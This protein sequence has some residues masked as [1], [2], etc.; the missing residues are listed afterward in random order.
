MKKNIF[1]SST[2]YSMP[3][4][5]ITVDYGDG[6]GEQSWSRAAPA[7]LW[8]HMY[9]LPGRYWVSVSS[10]APMLLTSFPQLSMS[11]TGQ[12]MRAGWRWRWWSR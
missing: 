4:V 11:W 2:G 6:S 5:I 1:V 7:N 3:P 10:R 9:Q 8:T 12:A